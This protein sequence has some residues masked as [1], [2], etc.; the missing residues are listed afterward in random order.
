MEYKDEEIELNEE[1]LMNVHNRPEV[2]IDRP[3][4]FEKVFGNRSKKEL[5]AMKEMLEAGRTHKEAIDN[6]RRGR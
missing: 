2:I 5:E 1:D 6:R 3:D 4:Q